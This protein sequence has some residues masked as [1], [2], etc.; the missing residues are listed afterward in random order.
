[1]QPKNIPIIILIILSA[2]LCYG[3][4]LCIN[5][6]PQ[7][8]KARDI[9]SLNQNKTDF[10]VPSQQEIS[11]VKDI[12]KKL[13]LIA[14]PQLDSQNGINLKLFG[15][16]KIVNQYNYKEETPKEDTGFTY[17]ITFTFVSSENRY[18]YI[19]KKFYKQGDIMPDGGRISSIETRQVLITKNN[20][21][22]WIPV[23]TKTSSAPDPQQKD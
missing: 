19:N 11:N 14:H 13:I 20:I 3:G 10:K 23:K 22:E 12:S 21:A 2:S 16:N 7:P 15:Q 8:I 5:Y 6:T 18:C 17:D 4:W 9:F 1:M